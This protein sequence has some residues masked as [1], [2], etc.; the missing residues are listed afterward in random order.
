VQARGLPLAH[1]PW[2]LCR[3]RTPQPHPASASLSLC[4]ISLACACVRTHSQ[5]CR[6]LQHSSRAMLG[7][8]QAMGQTLSR[9]AIVPQPYRSAVAPVK[10]TWKRQV[11]PPPGQ[12]HT[13]KK[14]DPCTTLAQ[15][16][17]PPA[18]VLQTAWLSP[19]VV[20]TPTPL[21][22]PHCVTRP[23]APHS[24][25]CW[26]VRP[27]GGKEVSSRQGRDQGP[28]CPVSQWW[29]PQTRQHT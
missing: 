1:V 9:T 12:G 17:H 13:H 22:S 18:V 14:R 2:G 15:A 11:A 16:A 29:S 26:Q 10:G 28:A 23:P 3:T 21:T 25:Y 27:G 6:P 20:R 7:A 4:C 19:A 5:V 24:C 8:A